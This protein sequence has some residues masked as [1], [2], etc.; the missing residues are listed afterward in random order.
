MLLSNGRR[1]RHF[2][3]AE[4]PPAGLNFVAS[5]FSQ[6]SKELEDMTL[7]DIRKM[8]ITS[9]S[10]RKAGFRFAKYFISRAV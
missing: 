8:T 7:P 1:L 6:D 5:E 10:F 9:R 4:L 2:L 3:R